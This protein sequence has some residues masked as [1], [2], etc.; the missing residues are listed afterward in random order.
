MSRADDKSVVAEVDRFIGAVG[1]GT[2]KPSETAR[3]MRSLLEA[4]CFYATESNYDE[5]QILEE[6]QVY[7]VCP[8]EE[9]D[10][11]NRARATLTDIGLKMF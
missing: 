5:Q 8:M 6:G 11:G 3:K 10:R 1:A 2:L 9:D 7:F 4:L